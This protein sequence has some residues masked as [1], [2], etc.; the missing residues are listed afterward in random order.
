MEAAGIQVGKAALIEMGKATLIKPKKER[1]S[2]PQNA[3]VAEIRLLVWVGTVC[4]LERCL[5]RA[6]QLETPE[7]AQKAVSDVLSHAYENVLPSSVCHLL[8]LRSPSV[9]P[10][11]QCIRC[12]NEKYTFP[13]IFLLFP[14]EKGYVELCMLTRALRIVP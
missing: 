2:L 14:L 1:N 9:H 8:T 7:E 6:H 11:S 13:G 3:T 4:I 10:S 5:A 12:V